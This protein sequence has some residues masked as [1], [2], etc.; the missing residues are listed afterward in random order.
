MHIDWIK[1]FSTKMR[2]FRIC[3]SQICKEVGVCFSEVL[4]ERIYSGKLMVD[5]RGLG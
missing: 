2:G 4:L 5:V 1:F 3:S